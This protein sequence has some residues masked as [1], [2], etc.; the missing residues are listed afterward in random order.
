MEKFE[1]VLVEFYW[2]FWFGGVVVINVLVYCWLWLYYD[3]MV[4]LKYWFSWR[5]IMGFVECVGF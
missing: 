5:E 2:C 4:Y 3:E 1:E